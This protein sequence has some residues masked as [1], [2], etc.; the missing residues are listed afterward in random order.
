MEQ[1]RGEK[2]ELGQPLRSLTECITES[3][4]Q[5][6]HPGEKFVLCC[7][8]AYTQTPILGCTGVPQNN[9]RNNSTH[10]KCMIWFELPRWH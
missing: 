2:L 9:T 1:M 6:L 8:S 7:G 4:S 10:H 3:S 5:T